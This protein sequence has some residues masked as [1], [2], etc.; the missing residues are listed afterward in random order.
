MEKAILEQ[1]V[2][3][4]MDEGFKNQNNKIENL[5]NEMNQRFKEQDEKIEQ[6]FKAQDQKNY[7]KFKVQE[8][9]IDRLEKKMDER[10]DRIEKKIDEI[11]KGS[12]EIFSDVFREI[13]KVKNNYK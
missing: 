3:A 4:R 5:R 13:S 6:K 11:S 9:R 7:K 1:L 12:G 8:N 10:F 2:G